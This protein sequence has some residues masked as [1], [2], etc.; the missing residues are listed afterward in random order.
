MERKK[1]K[2]RATRASPAA[3]LGAWPG[4]ELPL[5]LSPNSQPGPMPL[6]RRRN[7]DA[8][9]QVGAEQRAEP[10]R[11][12]K[13]RAHLV[14]VPVQL[15]SGCGAVQ[16]EVRLRCGAAGLRFPAI[17][18][19]EREVEG[20]RERPREGS[21]QR[22][23]GGGVRGCAWSCGVPQPPSAVPRT[24]ADRLGV[25]L[26]RCSLQPSTLFGSSVQAELGEV[27]ISISGDFMPR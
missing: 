15:R 2:K 20:S 27:E 1:K 10:E 16:I 6:G 26:P 19:A 18:S 13:S 7:R 5:E 17:S 12:A 8:E 14:C 4:P 9:Q 25:L 21:A 24:A 3:A 22:C 11:G 23:G